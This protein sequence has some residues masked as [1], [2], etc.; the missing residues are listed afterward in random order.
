ME[1]AKSVK[2]S[3]SAPLAP[4]PFSRGVTLE[5]AQLDRMR[6]ERLASISPLATVVILN[7]LHVPFVFV[8]K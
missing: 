1:E 8:L 6:F 5:N 3:V 4:A 7:K 2:W